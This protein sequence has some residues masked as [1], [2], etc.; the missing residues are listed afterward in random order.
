VLHVA[1]ARKL[2]TKQRKAKKGGQWRLPVADAGVDQFVSVSL[3]ISLLACACDNDGEVTVYPQ[4]EWPANFEAGGSGTPAKFGSL[5]DM[6]DERLKGPE[7]AIAYRSLLV[8]M[9]PRAI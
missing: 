8:V 5:R 4:Q 9:K 3:P 6:P 7:A 1:R 2:R